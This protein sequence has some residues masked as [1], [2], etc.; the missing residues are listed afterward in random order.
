MFNAT[1]IYEYEHDQ[2]AVCYFG[3]PPIEIRQEGFISCSYYV[4]LLS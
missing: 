4:D 3:E 2:K 1:Y